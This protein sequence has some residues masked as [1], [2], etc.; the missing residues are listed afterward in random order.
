M[1]KIT[2]NELKTRGVSIL[3][4]YLAENSE[5]VITV[6]GQEKYVVMALEHYT[7]LQECELDTALHEAQADYKAGNYVVESVDAHIQRLKNTEE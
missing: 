6:H 5:I 7:Y 1:N 3:E 4:Q 2:A